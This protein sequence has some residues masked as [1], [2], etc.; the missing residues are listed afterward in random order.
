MG[1]ERRSREERA[2]DLCDDQPN[3]R[4]DE[5]A[6]DDAR[7][8]DG[9]RGRLGAVTSRECVRLGGEEEEDEA[10]PRHDSALVRRAESQ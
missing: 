1:L 4:C 7:V 2:G 10:P 6:E 8:V 9:K 5:E 3:R